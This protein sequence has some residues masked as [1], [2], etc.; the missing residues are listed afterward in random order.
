M[1]RRQAHPEPSASQT[2]Q[3]AGSDPTSEGA[4]GAQEMVTPISMT[5]SDTMLPV[6]WAQSKHKTDLITL[7]SLKT[8]QWL[9]RIIMANPT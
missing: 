7:T 4:V 5:S 6:S 9:S 2:H 8:L 1:G 3:V